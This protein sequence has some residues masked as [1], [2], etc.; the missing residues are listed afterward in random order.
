MWVFFTH[1]V[2]HSQTTKMKYPIV[3][4]IMADYLGQSDTHDAPFTTGRLRSLI[5]MPSVKQRLS[6]R[7]L[8]ELMHLQA[9]VTSPQAH[10]SLAGGQ[11]L[12]ITVR[13]C[14]IGETGTTAMQ[15]LYLLKHSLLSRNCAIDCS[16]C[17]LQQK[18]VCGVSEEGFEKSIRVMSAVEDIQSQQAGEDIQSYSKRV[19]NNKLEK[20]YFQLIQKE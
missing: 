6:L 1:S 7:R 13:Y 9:G 11:Q 10:P 20:M 4:D 12:K 16:T 19:S 3:T 5:F 17:R 2:T 14:E 8:R 18:K 15:H